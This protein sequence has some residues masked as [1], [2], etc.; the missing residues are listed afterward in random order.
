[1]KKEKKKKTMEVGAS[2][3]EIREN[4]THLSV[5]TSSLEPQ[6]AVQTE[7]ARAACLKLFQTGSEIRKSPR[8]PAGRELLSDLR[9]LFGHSHDA[10]QAV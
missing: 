1:M 5:F 4:A 3:H 8:T 6:K 9:S 7:R 10:T 2:V